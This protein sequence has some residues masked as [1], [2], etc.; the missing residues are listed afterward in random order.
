MLK[1]EQIIIE[2]A[3]H[4]LID[5]VKRLFFE[6]FPEEERRPWDDFIRKM[7]MQEGGF[8]L[9]A[10]LT[11]EKRLAG[12]I[13]LWDLDD[14]R[15]AEYLATAP[16]MRGNGLGAKIIRREIEESPKPLLLEV[17]MPETGEMASR[18]INFYRRN[19][20]IAH[21]DI[22]Y[23]QPPYSEGLPSVR[24][25]LMTTAPIKDADA[26]IRNLHSRVYGA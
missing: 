13:T 3:S 5:D 17:E 6:S 12:F 7:E 20:F 21:E 18:R 16:E 22:F 2:S 23:E 1:N 10:Y 15:Y 8:S 14:F 25:M 19:G 4:P 9:H 11:P 24:L 26:T